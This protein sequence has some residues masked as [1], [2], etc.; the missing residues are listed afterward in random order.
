HEA[1]KD[2]NT[3]QMLSYDAIY[4]KGTEGR[5]IVE[6]LCVR[7]HGPNFL[8]SRQ[9]GADQWNGAIDMMFGNGNPQGAMI[10]PGDL[11]K[12]QR[13]VLVKYLVENFGRAGQ[14]RAALGGN[15][16]V[17]VIVF[18]RQGNVWVTDRG[19]PNRIARLDTRTGDYSGDF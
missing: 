19:I 10:Q 7:C 18:Y 8:P 12:E 17:Q 11:T 3:V 5:Q 2:S 6:R 13:E 14:P 15:R 4:P 16:R 9:W 1:A